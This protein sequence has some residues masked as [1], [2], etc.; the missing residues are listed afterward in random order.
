MMHIAVDEISE[1]SAGA[2]AKPTNYDDAFGSM[3]WR[4]R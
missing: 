1:Y 3:P 4:A 2:I